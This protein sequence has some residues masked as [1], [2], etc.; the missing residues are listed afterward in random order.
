MISR[1][2]WQYIFPGLNQKSTVRWHLPGAG[3]K[4]QLKKCITG[5]ILTSNI[6][7]TSGVADTDVL[8]PIL[9]FSCVLPDS[10]FKSGTI[11]RSLFSHSFNV[12]V[13]SGD[14][15]PHIVLARQAVTSDH[16]PRHGLFPYQK[17]ASITLLHAVNVF[18]V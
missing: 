12:E 13:P 9:T 7:N 16:S 8:T 15:R 2:I 18:I 6:E 4:A 10:A 11:A 1:G 3:H 5:S 14:S 17:I